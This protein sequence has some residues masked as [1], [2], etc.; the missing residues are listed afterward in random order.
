MYVRYVNLNK[1]KRKK[2]KNKKKKNKKKKTL[3]FF[4]S[5]T[6]RPMTLKLGMQH[7]VHEYYQVCSNDDPGLILT[8]F[9]ARSN[10]LSCFRMGKR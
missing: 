2:K 3:K 1:V 6:K 10:L 4:F 5:G 7:W 8:Y 9:S